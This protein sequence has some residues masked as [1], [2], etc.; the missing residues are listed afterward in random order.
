MDVMKIA[1]DRRT[2]LRRD[3]EKLDE[4]I[5]MAESLIRDAGE[6][7]SNDME[8]LSPRTTTPSRSPEA[9]A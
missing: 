8:T 2:K 4:F 9:V 6:P 5:R 3:L 7:L 1:L